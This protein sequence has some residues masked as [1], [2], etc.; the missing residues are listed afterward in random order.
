METTKT[1][2]VENLKKALKS[3]VV[4][5]QYHK[6]DGSVRT[7]TGTTNRNTLSENYSFRGGEG[8]SRYGYTSYWDVDKGDWRCF[9]DNA[10]IGMVGE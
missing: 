6:K 9:A 10:L 7:A 3:G 8:P 5:F 2:M 4:K 1:M